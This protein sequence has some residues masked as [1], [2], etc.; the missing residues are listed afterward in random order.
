MG[1]AGQ[2][3]NIKAAQNKNQKKER[4]HTR[5]VRKLTSNVQAPI[6]ENITHN[7]KS[8]NV[9]KRVK[10]GGTNNIDG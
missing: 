7:N 6:K 9:N 4:V 2:E 1:R 10:T 3:A 8:I 5:R